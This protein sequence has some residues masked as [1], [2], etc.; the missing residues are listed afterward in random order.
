MGKSSNEV[1]RR[2]YNYDPT[3]REKINKVLISLRM[4]CFIYRC[5]NCVCYCTECRTCVRYCQETYTNELSNYEDE[6]ADI[7][8]S[9]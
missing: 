7:I 6:L 1:I 9:K 3:Y 2:I 5:Y 8:P 4:H